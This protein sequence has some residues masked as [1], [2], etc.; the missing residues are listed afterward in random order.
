MFDG[1]SPEVLRRIGGT[2]QEACREREDEVQ[3]DEAQEDGAQGVSGAEETG[4]EAGLG[5]GLANI[6]QRIMLLFD[7]GSD[8]LISNTGEGT[9]TDIRITGEKRTE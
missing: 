5:I 4:G 1:I 3:E 8:L 7:T 6:R 2:A 9:L